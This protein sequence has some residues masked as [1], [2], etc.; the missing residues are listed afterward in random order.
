MRAP[1]T[2]MLPNSPTAQSLSSRPTSLTNGSTL[3]PWET[4]H[5]SMPLPPLDPLEYHAAG[6]MTGN[7][8][9][10]P[11]HVSVKR[12][13]SAGIHHAPSIQDVRVTGQFLPA[14]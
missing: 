2:A 11:P 10:A 1:V 14:Q 8:L 9:T 13:E 6:N 4:R 3:P 7:G 5:S 12:R